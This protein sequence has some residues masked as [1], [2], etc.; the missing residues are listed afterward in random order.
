MDRG[1]W[2]K[3]SLM[4]MP[5]IMGLILLDAPVMAASLGVRIHPQETEMWCWA[6]SAEMVMDYLGKDIPQCIQANDRFIRRDCCQNPTPIPCVQGGWPQFEKYGFSYDKTNNTAL[7]WDE[8]KSQ[9]DDL[10]SPFCF[11]WLWNGGGGGHMMVVVGYRTA[12][13]KNY[14]EIIDP[15]PP[16]V[17]ARRIISLGEFYSGPDHAH[18]V[19][20]YNIKK[21]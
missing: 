8:I 6:A 11:S 13:G 21:E 16:H 2:L 15:Y 17:G 20:Y 14:V 7:S 10:K 12:N 3:T 19:D 4:L 18:W 5:I 9:I 1:K